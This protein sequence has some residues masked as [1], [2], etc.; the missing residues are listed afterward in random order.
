MP[1]ERKLPVANEDEMTPKVSLS[2]FPNGSV[3]YE[4]G[5]P[6]RPETSETKGNVTVRNTEIPATPR[7]FEVSFSIGAHLSLEDAETHATLILN[8]PVPTRTSDVPYREVED[9]AAQHLPRVLRE[10]ADLIAADRERATREQADRP[11]E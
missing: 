3:R 9:R 6:G 7:F 8:I 2:A 4:P 11:A 5:N 1:E 10:L